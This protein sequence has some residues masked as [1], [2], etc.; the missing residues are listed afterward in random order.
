MKN[1]LRDSYKMLLW[2]DFPSHF[3]DARFV[4]NTE[5]L[6]FL[7]IA[8]FPPPAECYDSAL[9]TSSVSPVLHRVPPTAEIIQKVRFSN[10]VQ[11][12]CQRGHL[13]SSQKIPPRGFSQPAV[14]LRIYMSTHI[15]E[16]LREHV[17]PHI[18]ECKESAG[19][20]EAMRPAVVRIPPFPKIHTGRTHW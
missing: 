12:L 1:K 11:S 16:P 15:L 13:K 5:C 9:K 6:N 4:I 8:G 17:T 10:F 19:H 3:G 14:Q 2:L 7:H 18:I 20:T